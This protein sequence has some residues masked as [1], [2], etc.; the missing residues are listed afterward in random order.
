LLNGCASLGKGMVEALL[1]NEK[2]ED[3]RICQIRGEPFHGLSSWV[4]DPARLA[5]VLIV[6]GVGNH[7]PGY[8]TQLMENLSNELALSHLGKSTKNIALIDPYDDTKKLGNLRINRLTNEDSSHALL[9][10]EL[11]WSEITADQKALLSYD[12]SGEYS[13]RR[14]AVNNVLKKFSNDT[15]PDPLIYLGNR[16]EDILVAFSQ[17]FCWMLSAQWDDMPETTVNQACFPSKHAIKNMQK[18]HFAFI[19]H[20]L[21]SR[22]TID[23]LQRIAALFG[24]LENNTRAQFEHA[25]ELVQ[26]FKEQ[27]I[28]I[29]MLSNQLPMLQLGRDLPEVTGQWDAYCREDGEHYDSRVLSETS[30]IAFNDPNDILSYAI[31]QGFVEQYIDSRLCVDTTNININVAKVIDAFGVEYPL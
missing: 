24:D 11:T 18:N 25:D 13:F 7:I 23:G 20:S 8:S 31:P 19:S 3:T 21:G 27:R 12:N 4:K 2:K 16:R 14:A 10:Y 28:P 9:F 22:I 5:K 17:S 6:H 30:I 29:F 1:D 15:A 26:A